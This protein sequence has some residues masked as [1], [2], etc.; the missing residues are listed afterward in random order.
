MVMVIVFCQLRLTRQEL[1]C[2]GG[3]VNELEP[4]VN[5]VFQAAGYAPQVKTV[6]LL[7]RTN[8]VSAVLAQGKLFR[9]RVVDEAGNP[10]PNAMVRTDSDDHGLIKFRW[11]TETDRDGR[12]SWDSAPAEPVLFWFEKRGYRVIRDLL[13]EADGSEHEIE[14]VRPGK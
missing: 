10:I 6:E 13:L 3:L 14:L 12:F 8:T 5:L 2:C 7:D 9:G 1:S 4:R 11:L